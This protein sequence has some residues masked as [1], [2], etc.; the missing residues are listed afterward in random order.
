MMGVSWLAWLAVAVGGSLGAMGRFAL[1]L[2][3]NR[4]PG[5][6]FPWGTLTA[7]LSGSFVIGL[8]FVYFSLRTGTLGDP[9][10]TFI[11]VGLLGAFTTFSTF[12]IE[13]VVL[14]QQQQWMLATL[15]LIASVL[16]SLIAVLLGLGVG[17]LL[18]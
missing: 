16:G 2:A 8:A 5:S 15:Y 12:A 13:S 10:R 11:V 18:F 3:Y 1:A 6:H 17:K 7:N 14:V 4:L 9:M